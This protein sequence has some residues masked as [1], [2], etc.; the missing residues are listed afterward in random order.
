[1]DRAIDGD[2]VVVGVVGPAGIGKSRLVRE[3]SATAFARGVEMFTT[4]CESHTSQIPFHIVARL[5]ARGYRSVAVTP[6]AARSLESLGQ[7]CRFGSATASPD[8]PASASD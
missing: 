2:G 3:L 7:R 4:F 1:L 5:F 8:R 6:L